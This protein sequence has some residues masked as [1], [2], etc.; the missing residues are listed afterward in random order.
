MGGPGGKAILM[1]LL[2]QRSS[3]QNSLQQRWCAARQWV[4][5]VVLTG[6][7]E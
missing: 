1:P 6:S 3:L 7:N 2:E 5:Y 4:G